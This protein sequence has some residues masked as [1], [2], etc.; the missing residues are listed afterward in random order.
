MIA[1][2]LFRVNKKDGKL[3][4]LFINRNEETKFGEWLKAECFPTKGFAIRQGWHCCLQPV[5][6]HLKL[7]LASGEHRVWVKCEIENYEYYE[8][9]ESQ[10]GT[11]VLAQSLKVLE[12]M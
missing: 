2:K 9:P 1:Y 11:W 3:Y 7:D 4:P 10:G 12:I 5:A 8:R 6:P